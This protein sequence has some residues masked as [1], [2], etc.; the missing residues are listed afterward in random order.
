M[1]LFNTHGST[2]LPWSGDTAKVNS[3]TEKGSS[4]AK[5]TSLK[6]KKN[7]PF[8]QF[9]VYQH[10]LLFFFKKSTSFLL[11]TSVKITMPLQKTLINRKKSFNISFIYWK[12]IWTFCSE[13]SYFRWRKKRKQTAPQL[14]NNT[15]PT[16]TALDAPLGK[17]LGKDFIFVQHRDSP[18]CQHH[19]LILHKE[20]TIKKINKSKK[21]YLFLIEIL[22]NP[23]ESELLKRIKEW[24]SP[25]F[26]CLI[27]S[28][29]NL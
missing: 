4:T 14:P 3:S 15:K 20:I 29:N 10:N 21:K 16:L 26:N 7:L 8:H 28:L 9:R 11:V 22:G 17:K 27:K 19:V 18:R 13:G 12:Q 25:W 2:A 24:F 23:P 1:K 5:N 6:H